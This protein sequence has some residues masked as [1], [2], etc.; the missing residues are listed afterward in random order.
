MTPGLGMPIMK[1]YA[2]V[3][4]LPTTVPVF[5]LAGA[6]LLPRTDLPLNIFEPRYVEMVE[7]A[8]GADR[9][10]G[11]IQPVAGDSSETPALVGV[12]CLGRI[13]SYTETN[14]GRLM[15]ALTGICRFEAVKEKRVKTP[16][17]QM[18]I[19]CAGFAADLAEAHGAR[20]VDRDAVIKAF[21]QYL[22]ANNM[23]ANW[24]EVEQVPTE[25]LV[26]TLSQ[27]A[28]Y[29]ALEKQALLEAENLEDRAAMLIALT[30]LA[31]SGGRK[32][33]RLQ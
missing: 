4:E 29:P 7:H 6:L 23:A 13:T 8:M 30:E 10:I 31:L 17:R 26:N 2:T 12:G 9:V 24:D 33:A 11:M 25:L 3:D 1:R 19:S 28:P 22:E 32:G 16:F 5:P 15:I 18:Q 21:R 20:S 14:D 27:L